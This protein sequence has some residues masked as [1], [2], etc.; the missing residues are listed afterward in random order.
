MTS[1]ADIRKSSRA[2]HAKAYANGGR[3]KSAKTVINVVVPPASGGATGAGCPDR[4]HGTGP[5]G[6]A[7]VGPAGLCNPACS[8]KRGAR[9]HGRRSCVRQRRARPGW[10]GSR[11]A[12][13]EGR[14]GQ[15]TGAIEAG[16]E[17]EVIP[18][19]EAKLQGTG[20]KIGT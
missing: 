18:S 2:A 5:D 13:G 15:R 12:C 1:Y 16:E 7:P 11:Q 10:Q 9:R 20:R 4:R 8:R 17:A 3:V 6:F 19:G 14:H